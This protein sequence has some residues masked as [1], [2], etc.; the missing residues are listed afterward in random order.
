MRRGGGEQSV[1]RHL[2]TAQPEQPDRRSGWP[3]KVIH[4]LGL[5]AASVL[6]AMVLGIGAFVVW[7]ISQGFPVPS[8]PPQR[9]PTGATPGFP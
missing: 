7:G 5:I 9:Q 2:S 8:D 3:A 6:S 1:R 4:I